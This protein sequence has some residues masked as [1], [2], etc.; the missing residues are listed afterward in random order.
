MQEAIFV[1]PGFRNARG[2]TVMDGAKKAQRPGS[3]A[4]SGAGSG[5]AMRS[6]S[7]AL[8]ATAGFVVAA[9][10]WAQRGSAPMP[11]SM[12]KLCAKAETQ[13]FVPPSASVRI[14]S[15][16]LLAQITLTDD[17]H[18]VRAA[19]GSGSPDGPRGGQGTTPLHAVAVSPAESHGATREKQLSA[20][21]E[22]VR[23]GATIDALASPSR[24]TPLMLAAAAG[25]EELAAFLLA[26]GADPKLKN[27][28]GQ[29]ATDMAKTRV[30]HRT[31]SQ[32]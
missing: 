24:T 20:A 29:T 22:L 31:L 14:P 26:N 8:L 1:I 28:R 16:P 17:I 27:A 4:A 9:S 18:R 5:K 30:R 13:R 3:G 6:R 25:N 19:M 15:D 21:A 11:Q 10:A 32:P 7:F 12:Q 2:Q 23:R